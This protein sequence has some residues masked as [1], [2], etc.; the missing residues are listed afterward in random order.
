VF[1]VTVARYTSTIL[2][3]VRRELD[4]WQTRVADIRDPVLRGLAR[5]ALGKRGNIEGAALFATLA[6]RAQRHGLVRALVCFQLAYNYLDVLGERPIDHPTAAA[7]ELHQALLVA[8]DL[9]AL[10]RDYY[11]R[12]PHNDDSGYLREVVDTC[13]AALG[14]LPSY[15]AVVTRV[16]AAAE[17]IVAFQ[18]L[19]LN[20][21][22]GGHYALKRWALRETPAGSGLTWA[23]MAA[24]AGSSLLV[25]ALIAAAAEPDPAAGLDAL[26]PAYFPH[27]SAL[28]SLLDSLVD[29]AEDEG[30]GQRSFLEYY[31]STSAAAL[32]LG[33]LARHAKAM[34]GLAPDSARHAVI[35]TAMASYYLSAPQS[36]TSEGAEISSAV[37]GALGRPLRVAISIFRARRAGFSLTLRSYS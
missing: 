23:E 11:A 15:D 20:E 29:R 16:Q 35:M 25:H 22:Q 2:P 12:Y 6:P 8:L 19:N 37:T 24:A 5:E 14:R 3:L 36:A 27:M 31:P 10:H 18:S 21:A 9:D 13:R 32:S 28:H 1:A 17:R 33:S 30:D 34:V 7:H 4:Y 26:E